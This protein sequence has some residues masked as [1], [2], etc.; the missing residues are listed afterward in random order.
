[1]AVG[2]TGLIC[3]IRHFWRHSMIFYYNTIS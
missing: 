2:A 3:K 1:M